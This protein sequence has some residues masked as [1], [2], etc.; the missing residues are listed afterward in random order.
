MENKLMNYS[1][2]DLETMSKKVAQ[3]NFLGTRN[4]NEVFTL[5]ML[6]QAEGKNPIQASMDYS[7]IQGKPALKSQACLVRF[8][9]AGGKIEYTKR[10]DN[11]CTIKFTHSQA[12]ELII[13][14]NMERARQAGLNLNK[15]NWKKYPRQMLAAR[16]IAEG[17]R[18]LYPACLDGLYLV[19]EVQDFD[20][21]NKDDNVIDVQVENDSVYNEQKDVYE[22]P[23]DYSIAPIGTIKGKKW[24]QGDLETLCQAKEYFRNKKDKDSLEYYK[25]ISEVIEKKKTELFKDYTVDVQ[26]N[27]CQGDEIIFEYKGGIKEAII[28]N[29]EYVK[30]KGNVVHYFELKYKDNSIEKIN[31][32]EVYKS[33]T[34][35]KPRDEKERE[36]SLNIK[37]TKRKEAEGILDKMDNTQRIEVPE[38]HVTEDEAPFSDDNRSLQELI[39]EQEQREKTPPNQVSGEFEEEETFF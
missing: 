28:L 5:L 22:N 3:S 36:L 14:W 17:V 21:P 13:T 8:Q 15:D 19:E 7:I 6:A 39:E 37:R 1:L 35:A 20:K 16:C 23:I 26:G 25:V 11:E 34:F 9:K 38:V 24:E 30:S 4:D 33:Y 29:D 32:K 27:A 18:A 31:G 12:G 2:T 10:D